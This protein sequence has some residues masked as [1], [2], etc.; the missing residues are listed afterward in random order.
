M[1]DKAK[2]FKVGSTHFNRLGCYEVTDSDG[3]AIKIKYENGKISAGDIDTFHKIEENYLKEKANIPEAHYITYDEACEYLANNE[4]VITTR[5]K[6]QVLLEG[7]T[8]KEVDRQK[9]LY[10]KQLQSKGLSTE[11]KELV[12]PTKD[13]DATQ[14]KTGCYNCKKPI[15]SFTHMECSSCKWIICP[16]CGSCGCGWNKYQL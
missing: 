12:R 9:A 8:Q 3:N 4:V 5:D 6:F 16:C 13:N 15:D 2:D 14:R 10:F 7:I 11:G 1:R